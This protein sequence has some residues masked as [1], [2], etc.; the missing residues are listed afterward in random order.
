ME[1]LY[2]LHFVRT[3]FTPFQEDDAPVVA[4]AVWVIKA[5]LR[6]DQITGSS[7]DGDILIGL[8]DSR[9]VEA[10]NSFVWTSLRFM[11]L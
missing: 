10:D 2:K 6:T 4:S 7:L 9:E 11:M 1:W 5:A 3:I 8:L